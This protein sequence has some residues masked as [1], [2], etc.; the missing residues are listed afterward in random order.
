MKPC[1]S[2]TPAVKLLRSG[3][4]DLLQV[5]ICPALFA[6]SVRPF[7]LFLSERWRL[8]IR[9]LCGVAHWAPYNMHNRPLFQL[10]AFFDG[11]KPTSHCFD[12]WRAHDVSLIE[13]IMDVI[14]FSM[15]ARKSLCE[16]FVLI[17][18]RCHYRLH[19]IR[20]I[21][22]STYQLVLTL[23][24]EAHGL[25]RRMKFAPLWNMWWLKAP[26]GSGPCVEVVLSNLFST[27][28]L[29]SSIWICRNRFTNSVTLFTSLPSCRV[30]NESGLLYVNKWIDLM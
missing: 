28:C 20:P 16:G 23:S 3:Q 25:H 13:R 21:S 27:C 8:L 11:L 18:H 26:G 4:S 17:L 15:I 29:F 22:R 6:H 2:R 1:Y 10:H 14:Y 12:L 19:L 7:F 9:T 5:W 30:S 24:P